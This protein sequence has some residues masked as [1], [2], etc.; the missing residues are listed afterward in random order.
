MEQKT[1]TEHNKQ[2]VHGP[3]SQAQVLDA[4]GELHS[5]LTHHVDWLKSRHNALLNGKVPDE[6][7]LASDAHHNCRFGL[8]YDGQLNPLFH[9]CEAFAEVGHNHEKM[10]ARVRKLATRLRDGEYLSTDD[11]LAFM[12]QAMSFHESIRHLQYQIWSLLVDTDP[13]TGLYNR[14]TMLQRLGA[15]ASRCKRNGEKWCVAMIDIDHFKNINDNHGHVIGDRVIQQTT[16]L[17][18][19]GT[20]PYDQ[21]FRYG[22]EEFLLCMPHCGAEEARVILERLR[23]QMSHQPIHIDGNVGPVQVNISCGIAACNDEEPIEEN[24]RHADEAL[25]RAK[26]SGRNMISVWMVN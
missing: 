25:Y 1:R 19:E 6:A 14:R 7:D 13:L 17:L 21:L 4:L 12:D 23:E 15:E 8:W 9:S 11:M 2:P 5:V 16:R 26:E 20:R 10:H 18:I 24:I 22:G 3:A